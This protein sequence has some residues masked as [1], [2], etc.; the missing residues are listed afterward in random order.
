MIADVILQMIRAAVPGVTV[1]DG[2][3]PD[4]PDSGVPPERYVVLY[5]DTGTRSA[6]TVE[7]RSTSETW[8]WQTTCVAPDRGMAAWLARRI[9]DA[10]TDTRPAVAGWSCGLIEHTFS[11]LSTSDELVQERP[12]VSAIDQYRLIAERL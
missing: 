2:R 11:Q 3:V 1:Y 7:H 9:G 6:E 12:V 4:S 5:V 10:L 8:R